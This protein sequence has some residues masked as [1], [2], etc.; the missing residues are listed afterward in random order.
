MA[1]VTT[2]NNYYEF[3]T[4]KD[5]PAVNARNFKT[6]PWTVTVMGWSSQNDRNRQPP[7]RNTNGNAGL[8]HAMRGSVVDGY[9]LVRIP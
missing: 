4:G 8:S 2:Y 1:N 9:T 3:G 6:R 5:E 7:Q